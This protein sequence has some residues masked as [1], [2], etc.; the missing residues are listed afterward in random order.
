M[1]QASSKKTSCAF[2]TFIQSLPLACSL[3]GT[4]EAKIMLKPGKDPK[5]PSDQPLVQ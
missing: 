2:N 5:F 4:L 1:S 3:S